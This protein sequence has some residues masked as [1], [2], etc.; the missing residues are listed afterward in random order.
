MLAVGKDGPVVM[1]GLSGENV[2]R[3]VAN[4]PITVDVAELLRHSP[5]VWQPPDGLAIHVV[6]VYGRTEQVLLDAVRRSVPV[7]EVRVEDPPAA[8]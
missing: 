8:P 1:F 4:E 3:L 6:L 5:H 2:A 7:R